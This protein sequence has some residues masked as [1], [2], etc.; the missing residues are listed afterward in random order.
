MSRDDVSLLGSTDTCLTPESSRGK[1]KV[2]CTQCNCIV[3]PAADSIIGKCEYYY[4]P[5][6]PKPDQ[7][8]EKMPLTYR[9]WAKIKAIF[10]R[11]TFDPW[12]D[13]DVVT[14]LLKKRKSLLQSGS[15]D[16]D[17]SR[18]TNFLMRHIGCGHTPPDYYASYGYY[19]C[20]KYGTVLLPKLSPAGKIWLQNTRKILQQYMED[21]L[22]QNMKNTGIKMTGKVGG[23]KLSMRNVQKYKL[24]IDSEMFR[25]FAFGT[26]PMA[27][28]DGG[29]ADLPFEDYWNIGLH[30]PDLG[31]YTHGETWEQVISSGEGVYNKKYKPGVDHVIKS[32]MDFKFGK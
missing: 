19:Y 5:L 13:Q 21:G 16:P 12:K 14:R 25:K 29:L 1:T 7:E 22:A 24:E 15:T 26:H 11:P 2:A 18:Y 27:Y 20:T 32:L 3:P 30:G 28:L 23:R 6:W 10:V 31:E 17:W 8:V 9:T 4:R